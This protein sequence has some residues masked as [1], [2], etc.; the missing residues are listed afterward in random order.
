MRKKSKSKTEVW[1]DIPGYIGKYQVSDR[2]RIRSR[3]SGRWK[4]RKLHDN[5]AGYKFISLYK[6]G[7]KLVLVHQIVA[8]MFIGAPY[9]PGRVVHHKNGKRDDN[10]AENLEWVTLSENSKMRKAEK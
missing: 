10:R 6:G 3:T 5:T 7:R 4:L 2:G 1:K 8:V 9:N